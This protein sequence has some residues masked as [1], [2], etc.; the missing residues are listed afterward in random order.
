[1]GVNR[2]KIKKNNSESITT[3]SSF[4]S[5]M[6][7]VFGEPAVYSDSNV[8][9]MY[10]GSYNNSPILV[11]PYL[12]GDG[13]S[14]SDGAIAMEFP[15]PTITSSD[16]GKFVTV[17]SSG[18]AYT[19]SSVTGIEHGTTAYWNS[20]TDY[21]PASGNIIIYDDALSIDGVT[22]PRFKV[23][24]GAYVSDLPFQDG[25]IYNH[26]NDTNIHVTSTEKTFWNNKLN[27]S[28]ENITNETLEF[29]R[30]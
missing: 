6:N 2:I 1:M 19:L 7:L 21:I 14:I 29:N 24:A 23:G 20:R 3:L 4:L 26:I 30:S 12:E 22:Y 5:E 13:I 11:G 18:D 16:G 17:N 15:L 28:N 25:W 27:I 8:T 9:R 10:I